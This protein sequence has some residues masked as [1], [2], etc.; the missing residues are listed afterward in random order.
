MTITEKIVEYLIEVKLPKFATTNDA[1]RELKDCISA[2]QDT[3]RKSNSDKARE[4][5][6]IKKDIEELI[7]FYKNT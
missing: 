5:R 2:L 3:V 6:D 7:L 1:D 4:L